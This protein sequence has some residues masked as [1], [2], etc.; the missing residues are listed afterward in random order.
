MRMKP[1]SCHIKFADAQTTVIFPYNCLNYI[2]V[3]LFIF[4]F[5]GIFEGNWFNSLKRIMYDMVVTLSYEI[6]ID[7]LYSKFS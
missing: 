7:K 5:S 4:M 3:S 1:H 2:K 6:Q